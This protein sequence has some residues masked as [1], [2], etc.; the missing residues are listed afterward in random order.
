VKKDQQPSEEMHPEYWREDLGTDV[1]GKYHKAYS[2]SVSLIVDGSK[3]G[4]KIDAVRLMPE[5]RD[6]I[7]R[8]IEGMSYEE[9]KRYI[10]ER[11]KDKQLPG[12]R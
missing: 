1:R 6:E 5:I 10:Q 9:E 2:D 8:E 4:V 3:T 11:L 7:S 12:D